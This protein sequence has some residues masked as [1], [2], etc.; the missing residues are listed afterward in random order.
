[1]RNNKLLNIV[2]DF[3]PVFLFVFFGFVLD[4]QYFYF[5]LEDTPL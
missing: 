3:F 2:S 4:G 1:M 5:S